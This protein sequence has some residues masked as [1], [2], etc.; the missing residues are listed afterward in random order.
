MK[1]KININRPE[2]SSQEIAKR[3]DFD[4]VLKQANV[5][6]NGGGGK[7]FFRKPWF[8]SGAVVAIVAIVATVLITNNNK[9]NDQNVVADNQQ[10]ATNNEQLVEEFYKTEEAK[11]CIN[12][13]VPGLNVPYESFRITSEKGG[14]INFKTGS[15]IT[16]PKNAFTDATGNPIKGEVE[17]RYREFH[18]AADFF[19]S[20]I[21][22]TYDSAGTRYQF[23]SAG[24]V[25]MLAFQDGKQVNM[26]KGKKVDIQ[27]ASAQ[28]GN[29]YNLY[30]LDTNI[31]NWSCLGKD[32]VVA[33]TTG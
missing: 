13:P 7:P 31:N 6:G 2:I 18:D 25:E 19:V 28:S 1:R 15:V 8:L 9:N 22:M 16:I 12:P 5:G 14:V 26:A 29:E 23:E 4:S 3:K 11:P 20:G 17:V 24:M 30:K 27:L 33:K 21:P 10:Q 32:R